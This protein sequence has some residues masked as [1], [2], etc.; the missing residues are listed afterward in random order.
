VVAEH[1]S[2][3]QPKPKPEAEAPQEMTAEEVEVKFSIQCCDVIG[4]AVATASTSCEFSSV[5]K[6][7]CY[8]VY[9]SQLVLL[10]GLTELLEFNMRYHPDLY[11]SQKK[12][13]KPTRKQ[14]PSSSTPVLSVR[15]VHPLCLPI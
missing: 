9:R 10:Q 6:P 4:T 2:K 1:D 8:D 14:A 12:P 5:S 3:F 11:K 7:A 13:A 15:N